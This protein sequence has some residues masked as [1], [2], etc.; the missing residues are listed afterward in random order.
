MDK[1]LSKP[2]LSDDFSSRIQS[3]YDVLYD[4]NRKKKTKF[5]PQEEKRKHSAQKTFDY[6]LSSI[7]TALSL[8]K[9]P[10]LSQQEIVFLMQESLQKYFPDMVSFHIESQKTQVLELI[11]D[12]VCQYHQKKA[13][14]KQYEHI[15]EQKLSSLQDTF[16]FALKQISVLP[17]VLSAEERVLQKNPS[18][19]AFYTPDRVKLSPEEAFEAIAR[20]IDDKETQEILS[21]IKIPSALKEGFARQDITDIQEIISTLL[22]LQLEPNIEVFLE[23]FH[24]DDVRE[25]VVFLLDMS[26]VLMNIGNLDQADRLFAY[27]E[28]YI[29]KFSLQ[30]MVVF[31]VMWIRNTLYRNEKDQEKELHLRFFDHLEKKIEAAQTILSDGYTYNCKENLDVFLDEFHGEY[32]VLKKLLTMYETYHRSF[33]HLVQEKIDT[34]RKKQRKRYENEYKTFSR[35]QKRIKSVLEKISTNPLDI[36]FVKTK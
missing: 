33:L 32:K 20:Y 10:V 24:A 30:S 28:K 4:K 17:P 36:L 16:S 31:F 6:I 22:Y 12:I 21:H 9:K 18:Y 25:E 1:I 8:E 35:Q 15:K 27:S 34:A 7:N 5:S 13:E 11:D 19:D 23:H 26:L 2:T 3:L 29:S 14:Q